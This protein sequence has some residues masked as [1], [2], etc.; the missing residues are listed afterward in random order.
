MKKEKIKLIA[1]H[2][3]QYHCIPENDEWWG[4]GFTE[5]T[6]VKR[7]VPLFDGHLQPRV[8]LDKY[9]YNL[10]DKRTLEWQAMLTR[11]YGVYGLCFYH[12]WF[13][14]KLLLE[15]PVEQLL[16]YKE[17]D[18]N[19]CFSWANEPWSRSWRGNTKDI[20]MPQEYGDQVE[21]KAHFKYLLPFFRDSRYIKEDGKPIL[22]IYRTESIPKCDK[23]IKYWNKLAIDE[24]LPGIYIVETLN[25]MQNKTCCAESKA[26]VYMEPTLKEKRTLR[27]GIKRIGYKIKIGFFKACGIKC[28]IIENYDK[29]W[30]KIINRKYP[31]VEKKIFL[32]AFVGWDDSPRKQYRSRVIRGGTPEKFGYYLEKQILKAK[33]M[34]SSYIF[35]NAW[36]E[37]AEGTYLE[38]DEL[39]KYGYL[40]QIKK[41]TSKL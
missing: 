28:P 16:N 2:L 31:K 8:P 40:E 29:V 26:I 19:F 39:F 5:W 41:I 20:I 14:G 13:N 9:Y 35:I 11:K 3:P 37:W 33:Q 7:A 27:W 10:L 32:G 21:W 4:K 38:P 1:W 6:N 34:R 30:K 23:M 18:I 15:K 25:Y 12:Y 36:N 22:L 17:I 24:G